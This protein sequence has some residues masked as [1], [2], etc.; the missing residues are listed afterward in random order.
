MNKTDL[1]KKIATLSRAELEALLLQLYAKNAECKELIE[2]KFDPDSEVRF[3]EKYKK[4]IS[5]EFFPDRGFGKLRYSV[6]RKALKG[7]RD[8]STNHE[9]I[10]ELMMIHV[11]KGVAFT[12][13]YGD[14][15]A[16]FYDNIAGMYEKALGYIAEHNLRSKFMQRC[17]A[18][19]D[20]T[21]GMG[22]G[23]HD[24]LRNL[25]FDF[26]LTEE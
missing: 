14:I 26:E 19:V 3:F 11:E 7:F 22:W 25:Y 9:L 21:K 4:Q 8:I 6:M 13:E 18:V 16:K 20:K 2:V 15:D 12:N 24:E 10:T 17:R 5:S 23:F 1:K